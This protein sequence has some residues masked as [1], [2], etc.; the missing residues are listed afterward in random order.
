MAVSEQLQ[1][2]LGSSMMKQTAAYSKVK[3]RNLDL[4]VAW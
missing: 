1:Y 2:A 4:Q 3:Y